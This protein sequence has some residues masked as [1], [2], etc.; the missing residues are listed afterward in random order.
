MTNILF[1][2]P[3]SVKGKTK[4]KACSTQFLSISNRTEPQ[5]PTASLT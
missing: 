2:S 4:S 5:Q 1:L 3:H